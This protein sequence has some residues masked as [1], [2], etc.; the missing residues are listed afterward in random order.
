MT[1]CGNY[2]LIHF[3]YG[4]MAFY[5]GDHTLGEGYKLIYLW[6]IGHGVQV[7]TD[8][9]GPQTSSLSSC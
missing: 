6:T 1:I 2:A 9:Y 8:L 5:L 7:D 3:P 4:T